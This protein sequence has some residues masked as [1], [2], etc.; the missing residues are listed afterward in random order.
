MNAYI[1]LA[2]K[3]RP[4]R[5]SDVIGQDMTL[6]IITR[7]IQK[8]RLGQSLL[9]SG[10]RGIGKTTIARIVAKAFRCENHT[11][12]DPEPCCRCESCLNFAKG[13]QIDVIEIDAASNTSVDDVREI[14][15][16]SKYRPTIGKFK[17]FIIDEVHML[18]K[19]AF[20]ALLKTL[21]EPPP[22]VKFLFATTE[23]YK[24]PET[25]MSRVLKFDLKRIDVDLIAQ[26]LSSVCNQE[27]IAANAE[28]LALIARAADGSIRDSLSILDQA[29]NISENN[30]LSL[31][32]VKDML[33]IS[34][35]DDLI[36][37]LNLI[38]SADIKSTVKKYREIIKNNVSCG[39]IINALMDYIHA[40]TCIKTNVP[41]LESIVSEDLLP[42]LK[43]LSEKISLASASKI[44][45]M[46]VK[47]M[48]ELKFCERPEIVL[49]MILIRIA[50]ASEL[51]DLQELIKNISQNTEQPLLKNENTS[52]THNG[53]KSESLVDTALKMF[54]N[55]KIEEI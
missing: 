5:F 29:I 15:E 47:G 36:D 40:L 6:K 51:P 21:E 12:D 52:H 55:A 53:E 10:T 8:N 46:L 42:K 26:Y 11:E 44:W 25:I 49:E 35:D 2:T 48:E 19:S 30:E 7:G 45:Q 31:Q 17:I 3:Y 33:N 18:S 27:K 32:N 14:I 43:K 22:H 41:T 24:I 13:N 54:S 28:A 39:K 38:F 23:T 20:N 1:P 34:D 37:L 16:S 50:Y 9:F 4:Q